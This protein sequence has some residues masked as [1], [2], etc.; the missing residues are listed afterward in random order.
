VLAEDHPDRL[1]SQQNLA[2]AYLANGQ[3]KEAVQLLEHVVAIRERVLADDHPHRLASQGVLAMARQ[4]DKQPDQLELL[5]STRADE[6]GASPSNPPR[7]IAEAKET[8]PLRTQNI[9]APVHIA[10]SQ[11]EA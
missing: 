1:T 2:K 10:P 8:L 6:H 4:A 5:P 9:G 7:S 3:V 11:V